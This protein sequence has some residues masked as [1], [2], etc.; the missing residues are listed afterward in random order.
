MYEVIIVGG[1]PAGLSA[2]LVLGRC[3]RKVLLFD[4]LQPRN[5][6][7]ES[8][9]GFL[10]RD[11]INPSEFLD[12]ARKDLEKYE[13][14]IKNL[15][16]EKVQ[17]IAGGFEV[18]DAANKKYY[19]KKI[20]LATGIKD[21]LP[22]INGIKEFYGKSIFHCPYCDGYE[23]R[24]KGIAVYGKGNKAIGLAKAM[25][26]WSKDLVYCSDGKKLKSTEEIKLKSAGIRINTKKIRK[27]EGKNGKLQRIV[28]SDGE[29][30]E[31]EAM[32]FNNGSAQ[33]SEIAKNL[34]CHF[35]KKGV[36]LMDKMQHTN[37]KGVYV[38]G[39]CSRDMQLVIVAAAEGAKAG[40]AINI[41]L[42]ENE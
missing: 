1:G 17:C 5:R 11:G 28:F 41:A 32:F 39:D 6:F 30:L 24:D 37:I 9:H 25:L 2:A 36:V 13:L 3:R 34:N 8:M 19:S 27:L 14:E 7:T 35:T 20:L 4:T 33:Q 29:I 40:V 38:A 10:T 12:L 15:R 16:I 22:D 18:I 26:T 23:L 21:I 31:R 42:A